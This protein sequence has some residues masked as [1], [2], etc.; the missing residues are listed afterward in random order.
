ML[1]LNIS[2]LDKLYITKVK[3]YKVHFTYDGI[4]YVLV[5]T[6]DDDRCMTLYKRLYNANTKR[7]Y[8]E[9]MYSALTSRTPDDVIRYIGKGQVYSQIDK[10]YFVKCL[11]ELRISDGLFKDEY[12][13]Y[14]A[15]REELERKIAELYSEMNKIRDNW[16]K[17]S[18]H[19][20]KT[21]TLADSF[22]IK[23]ENN[24]KGG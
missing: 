15:S 22:K 5:D 3:P 13:K 1:R 4:K 8:S 2:S 17:T 12:N 19:G 21:K 7:Y 23:N 10:E 24:I 14:L 16:I 9:Y 20:S 6:S 11:V 18:N